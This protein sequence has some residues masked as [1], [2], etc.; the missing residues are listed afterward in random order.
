MWWCSF[1][2]GVVDVGLCFVGWLDLGFDVLVVVVG[3]NDV[4]VVG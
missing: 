2:V 1:L 4:V 3:F